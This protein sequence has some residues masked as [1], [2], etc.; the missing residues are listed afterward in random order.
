MGKE[1]GVG[2]EMLGHVMSP[3]G[4]SLRKKVNSYSLVFIQVC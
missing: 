3:L 2:R 1:A 4:Q